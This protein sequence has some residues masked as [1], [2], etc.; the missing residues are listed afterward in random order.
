MIRVEVWGYI[1]LFSSLLLSSLPSSVLTGRR[2]QIVT[3]IV[4]ILLAIVSVAIFV[5]MATDN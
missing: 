5:P 1:C 4:A 2:L 3:N